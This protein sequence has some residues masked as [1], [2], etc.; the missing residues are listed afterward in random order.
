M[1]LA[2]PPLDADRRAILLLAIGET[3]AWAA[4]F[5]SFPAML[6]RWEADLG[7]SKAELTGAVTLAILAAALASPLAGRVID[8]GHGALLMT[9]SAV[10]GGVGL[11]GLAMVQVLWQFYAVWLMIGLATARALYDPCFSLVTRARGARAKGGI[12]FITLVAGFAGT[13]SFPSVY[14]LS[15]A[16]GW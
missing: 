6:L 3:L 9:G 2:L 11:A 5:Y 12:I 15:E 13:V 10:L 16:F 7:W 8:R 4:I 1:F 14:W